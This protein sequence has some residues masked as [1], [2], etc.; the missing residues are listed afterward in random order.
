MQE[1]LL[2]ERVEVPR[3][4]RAGVVGQQIG[5]GVLPEFLSGDGGALDHRALTR[6]EPV[7]PRGKH[8]LD[9]Q[10]DR[11]LALGRR[12]LREHR[13]DLLEEQRIALGRLQYPDTRT[14]GD[15]RAERVEEPLALGIGE[16][17]E[18]ER[19]AAPLRA[20]LQQL[21]T[22]EAKKEHRGA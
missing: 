11:D 4:E 3:R 20:A 2:N 17:L 22:G 14:L 6:T 16:T 21:R 8:R 13:E 7:Q 1:L 18:Q 12:S 9:R 19:A 10:W 5:D 15:V